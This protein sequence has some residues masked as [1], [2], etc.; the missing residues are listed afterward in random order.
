MSCEPEVILE[1]YYGSHQPAVFCENYI[2]NLAE[3]ALDH[4]AQII[5]EADRV[6][7][8]LYDNPNS[9]ELAGVDVARLTERA[10]CAWERILERFIPE[11]GWHLG[12]LDHDQAL[13]V[14]PDGWEAENCD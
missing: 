11:E 7:S 9:P 5:L 8:V 14:I 4:E 3:Q 12:Y 13:F 2:L 10:N 6:V 1:N